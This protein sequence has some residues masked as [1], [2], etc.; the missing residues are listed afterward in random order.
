MLD[1][2]CGFLSQLNHE[3]LVFTFD[4]NPDHR[5]GSRRPDKETTFFAEFLFDLFYSLGN[6]AFVGGSLVPLGG[7]NPLEAV[8]RG[9]PVVFGNHMENFRDIAAILVESAGGFQIAD[10]GELLKVVRSWLTDPAR[11][12]EQGERAQAAMQL[13]QGAVGRNL[14]VIRSVLGAGKR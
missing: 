11:C 4:H 7:H 8:Q 13:H 12:R 14:E 3:I 9:L 6:F 1:G 5:L 2:G 10:E